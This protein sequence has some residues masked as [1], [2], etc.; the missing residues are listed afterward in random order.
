MR[1][2]L[3]ICISAH[4]VK[5]HMRERLAPFLF[6]GANKQAGA[7]GP[8]GPS[9][10]GNRKNTSRRM[11]E[12]DHPPNGF[13][14]LLGGLEGVTVAEPRT[15]AS[16]EHRELVVSRLRPWKRVLRLPGIKPPPAPPPEML[17]AE[18]GGP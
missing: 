3:P 18:S 14:D 11:L 17:V 10:A 15:D 4:S 16:A 5:W 8:V 13:E 9:E 2:P 7:A 12:G 1:A 6:V